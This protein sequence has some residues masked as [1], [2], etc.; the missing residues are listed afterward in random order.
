[1]QRR[2]GDLFRRKKMRERAQAQEIRRL[3]LPFVPGIG[4]SSDISAVQ[5]QYG[6]GSGEVEAGRSFLFAVACSRASDRSVSEGK[7]LTWPQYTA[8]CWPL[9]R[10]R[11]QRNH[12]ALAIVGHLVY[13]CLYDV[14][15]GTERESAS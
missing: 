10:L 12:M 9:L 14:G 13:L 6:S 3:A 5:M 4:S 7:V 8:R 1:M 15:F 2:R 11:P